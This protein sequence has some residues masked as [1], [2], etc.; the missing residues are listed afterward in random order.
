MTAWRLE[1]A[2]MYVRPVSSSS[3]AVPVG[4]TSYY[5]SSQCGLPVVV[6]MI[7]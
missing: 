2:I 3:N 1:M 5:R 4:L 7:T 6:I